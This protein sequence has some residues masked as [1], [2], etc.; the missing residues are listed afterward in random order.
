MPW[1]SHGCM[2]GV[3]GTDSLIQL[4]CFQRIYKVS[5]TYLNWIVN[6]WGLSLVRNV[7]S[8]AVQLIADPC[9]R[10]YSISRTEISLLR[11]NDFWCEWTLLTRGILTTPGSVV[12]GF[13]TKGNVI[14]AL[15]WLVPVCAG[16]TGTDGWWWAWLELPSVWWDSCS[17]NWSTSL[18][19][20]SGTSL[21]TSYTRWVLSRKLIAHIPIRVNKSVPLR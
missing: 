21:K 12:G 18:V 6:R 16:W 13:L 3:I 10:L 19:T 1:L 15:N 14:V 17:T 8:P 20:L 4:R 11:F 9:S 7:I 2:V 5:L